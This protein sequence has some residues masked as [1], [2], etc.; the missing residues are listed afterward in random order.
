[1]MVNIKMYFCIAKA[2]LEV[3]II[4]YCGV[5]DGIRTNIKKY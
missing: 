3:K 5:N 1:M 4:K 2:L